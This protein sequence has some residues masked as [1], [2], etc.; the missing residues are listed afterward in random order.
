[1]SAE[2]PEQRR[3]QANS[4]QDGAEAES[5]GEARRGEASP[6]S[7]RHHQDSNS[8]GAILQPGG[9]G[10]ILSLQQLLRG[11]QDLHQSILLQSLTED[12]C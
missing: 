11:L 2:A 9:R 12:R 6:D 10:Q 1:M 4:A 3:R 8:E 5:A 7:S